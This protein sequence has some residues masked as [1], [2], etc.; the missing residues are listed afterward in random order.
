MTDF[1]DP[2]ADHVTELASRLERGR[3]QTSRYKHNLTHEQI[4]RIACRTGFHVSRQYRQDALR[5]KAYR[6]QKWGLLEGGRSHRFGDGHSYR[7]TN[8]GKAVLT[9]MERMKSND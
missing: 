6:M 9:A 2:E 3:A 1:V 8:L 4:L 7:A 5:K